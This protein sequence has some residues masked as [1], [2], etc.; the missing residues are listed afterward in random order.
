MAKQQISLYIDDAAV[1]VIVSRGRQPQKWSSLPLE[2]GL[3]KDGLV[4]D[5]A[6]VAAKLKEL[7]Q[8]SKLGQR[9]WRWL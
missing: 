4:R 1:H 6:V 8:S 5:Q 7:W 2:P 9:R 3:V